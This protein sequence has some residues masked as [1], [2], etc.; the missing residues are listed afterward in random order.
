MKKILPII[1]I[2]ISYFSSGQVATLNLNNPA[3]RVGSEIEISVSFKAQN[4]KEKEGKQS[5]DEWKAHQKNVL[6]NGNIKF[7]ESLLDTGLVKIGPFRFSIGDKEFTSDIITVRVYPDLP[8]VK[9]G[10]WARL[11]NFKSETFLI[12]EQRISNQWKRED[13]SNDEHSMTHDSDGVIYASI[14]VE[15]LKEFGLVLKEISASTSS[16]VVDK[17]DTFGSGTVSYKLTKY[18]VTKLDNFRKK[19]RIKREH[20]INYPDKVELP[21]IEVE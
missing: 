20:F 14:E 16:Q 17:S 21:V 5:V 7:K 1:F 10:I 19:V 13:K 12:L 18:K 9:D 3:P 15:K 6:G 8:D 2:L 11:V 4:I